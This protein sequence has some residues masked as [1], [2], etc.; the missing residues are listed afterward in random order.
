[1]RKH[2]QKSRSVLSLSVAAAVASLTAATST[3]VFAQQG[4]DIQLEE[5]VV[6]G[7]R[8]AGDPNAIASQPV[9]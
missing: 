7:S 6:T 8:I 5:V 4:E 9:T 3:S 2:C 1:M